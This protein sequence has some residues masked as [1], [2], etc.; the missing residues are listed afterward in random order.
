[1]NSVLV[2]LEAETAHF[3]LAE[4]DGLLERCVYSV[5]PMLTKALEAHAVDPPSLLLLFVLLLPLFTE[6]I[7]VHG[8]LLLVSTYHRQLH[9]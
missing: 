6:R 5:P 4:P 7:E 2:F 9:D 3:P 8:V 1:M